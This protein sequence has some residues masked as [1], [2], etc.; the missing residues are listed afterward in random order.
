MM[1]H[2]HGHRASAGFPF[3]R[4]LDRFLRGYPT[5]TSESGTFEV[6]RDTDGVTLRTDV[7]GVE[8]AAISVTVDG[9]M[10][11]VEAA[12]AAEPGGT[13]QS[14]RKPRRFSHAFQLSDDLDTEAI[15]ANCRLGVL[16]LRI[17]K[18]PEA[19]PR[20]VEIAVN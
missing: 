1:L 15:Q 4:E 17:P 8:P 3:E 10:L 19:R 12:R 2:V 13:A 6:T 7:P 9:R 11:K 14:E 20:Q 18:R 16:T 5:A